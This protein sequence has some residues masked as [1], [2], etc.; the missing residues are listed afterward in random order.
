MSLLTDFWK[1]QVDAG[2]TQAKRRL[3]WKTQVDLAKISHKIINK[4]FY[5][6]RQNFPFL[7]GFWKTHVAAG[8]TQAKRRLI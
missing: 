3:I 1:T 2:Q 5:R 4:I 8:Q 6:R 7:A